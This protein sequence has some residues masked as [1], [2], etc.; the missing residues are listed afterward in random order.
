MPPSDEPNANPIDDGKADVSDS[1]ALVG[2]GDQDEAILG[3]QPDDAVDV[4]FAAYLKA[5]DEQGSGAREAFLDAFPEIAD[6]LRQL[7]DDAEG[8]DGFLGLS[9]SRDSDRG[10]STEDT[11]PAHEDFT[12]AMRVAGLSNPDSAFMAKSADDST[13]RQ[14]SSGEPPMWSLEDDDESLPMEHRPEGQEGPTLPYQLGDY[15]LES[16][17][18]R[19]GMGVVY[20]A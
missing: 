4:I 5:R 16:I 13:V 10:T 6:E 14:P 3:D 7:I 15:R 2:R 11:P 1:P 18:G 12:H 20:L 17:L 19:G 9:D 8:M